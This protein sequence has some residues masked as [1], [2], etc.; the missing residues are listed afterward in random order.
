ADALTWRK[1]VFTKSTRMARSHPSSSSCNPLRGQ[2][3]LETQCRR[4][5]YQAADLTEIEVRLQADLIQQQVLT[6]EAQRR[7]TIGKH[8]SQ[9]RPQHTQGRL[10]GRRSCNER[11]AGAGRS[12]T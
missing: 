9:R 5:P 11:Q 4:L 12:P 6:R 7:T 2:H 8:V 10:V 1:C 3:S